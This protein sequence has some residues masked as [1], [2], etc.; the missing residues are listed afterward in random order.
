MMLKLQLLPAACGDCLWLEYGT[1]PATR[2]VIIDGGLR[3][4]A[5][6]LSERIDAARRE[7][8]AETLDVELLVVT[9]IDN[10][11]ILGIIALLKSAPTSLRVKDVW[12]NG[13]SQLMR[14][15]TPAQSDTGRSSKARGGRPVD[16][17]GGTDDTADEDKSF[18]D[19]A[20]LPS[21]FDLLGPQQGD[22][23]SEL[24]STGRL[25]WNQHPRWQGDAVMVPEIGDL[26]VVTLDGG[27]RLTLLGP[28]FAR[29]YKL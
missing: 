20:A 1:P 15:P 29:L 5:R 21:P 13:R 4:T 8:S 23:L 25:P 14:L 24:L 11:H 12:F 2:V 3:E 17:M 18:G 19:L 27:L 16:L 9:H 6:T 22:E 28:P 10:D 26:P 7:R